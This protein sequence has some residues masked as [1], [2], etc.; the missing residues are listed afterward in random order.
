VGAVNDTL[1]DT[2]NEARQLVLK[3]FEGVTI[4]DVAAGAKK[5]RSADTAISKS[6]SG[7]K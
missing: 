1:N 6:G 2:F 3:R 5:R 7:K 4:A